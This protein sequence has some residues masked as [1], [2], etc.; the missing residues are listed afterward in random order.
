M[1]KPTILVIGATG[2]QGGSVVEYLLK[3]GHYNVAALTR[4]P[5]KDK[6]KALESKGVHV[7]KGDLSDP[8]SLK[9]AFKG[10]NGLF[11]VTQFWE[12]FSADQE[13]ADDYKQIIVTLK[14]AHPSAKIVVQSVLPHGASLDASLEKRQQLLAISNKR[15]HTFNQT[16]ETIAK[17]AEVSYLDLQPLVVDDEGYLRA[18]F[19]TDGLHLNRQGYLVWRSA[20]QIFSQLALSQPAEKI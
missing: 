18:E 10:I 15:I 12:K 1:S 19:T 20:I 8:V 3:S 13:L 9:T 6:A 5:T 4:D 2:A 7:F 11:L 14:Q 16:L 17:S